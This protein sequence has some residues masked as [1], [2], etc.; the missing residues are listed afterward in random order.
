MLKETENDIKDLL[1]K[2]FTATYKL[3]ENNWV[4]EGR[5]HHS[6]DPRYEGVLL[7]NTAHITEFIMIRSSIGKWLL[8]GE[9]LPE[10]ILEHMQEIGKAFEDE[11]S[12]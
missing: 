6:P 9:A 7:L 3:G 12:R 11:S 5:R 1:V 4:F 8:T 10:E 2:P